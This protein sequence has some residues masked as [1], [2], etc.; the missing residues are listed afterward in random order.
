MIKK[1]NKKK[2]SNKK[3]KIDNSQAFKNI[4]KEVI[5]T[6]PKSQTKQGIPKYVADRMAK[7]IFFTAGIPT[8][9]G[10][11]VFVI[12]YIIVTKIR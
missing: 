9:L 11:S 6:V 7:R 8:L 5:K 12:S 1:Q 10:M 3:K 4:E 2:S